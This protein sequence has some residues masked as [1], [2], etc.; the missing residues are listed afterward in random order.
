MHDEALKCEELSFKELNNYPTREKA[1]SDLL[2]GEIDLFID[3]KPLIDRRYQCHKIQTDDLV[4]LRSKQFHGDIIESEPKN[5]IK[6]KWLDD[7]SDKFTSNPGTNEYLIDS[8]ISFYDIIENSKYTGIVSEQT[9][10][11][12]SHEVYSFS[13]V[14]GKMDLYLIVANRNVVNKPVLK[15]II[16][17]IQESKLTLR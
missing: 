7:Y 12:L 11:T 10:S 5:I 15:E 16:K 14:I 9:A 1:Y 17:K 6:L 3:K 4:F 13:G 8:L 2:I